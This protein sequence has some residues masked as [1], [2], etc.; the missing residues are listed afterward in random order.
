MQLPFHF[1]LMPLIIF[2]PL[3]LLQELS[4]HDI[5]MDECDNEPTVTLLDLTNDE[6]DVDNET[7]TGMR[8]MYLQGI[9]IL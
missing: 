4:E 6:N 8:I 3:Y 1:L 5:Y 2:L 7:M 9:N